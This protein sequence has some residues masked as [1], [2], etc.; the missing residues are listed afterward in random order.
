LSTALSFDDGKT[1]QHFKN[2]ESLDDVTYI[3]PPPIPLLHGVYGHHYNQP[4]D[5]T[6]YIRAPGSVRSCYP[7]CRVLDDTVIIQYN[8]GGSNP[9][10]PTPKIIIKRRV[11]PVS[12]FTE[13]K[14]N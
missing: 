2:L 10:D 4:K 12:W 1:W 6:R 13:D 3:E 11:L 8:Y 9:E 5:R 7:D 14:A